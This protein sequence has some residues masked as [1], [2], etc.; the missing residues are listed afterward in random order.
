MNIQKNVTPNIYY[1]DNFLPKNFIDELRNKLLVS[2]WGIHGSDPSKASG[3]FFWAKSLTDNKH[4][5]EKE[6][7]YFEKEFNQ[8]KILRIYVNGQSFTQH[9]EFHVDDGERTYLI[10]MSEKI[11]SNSGGATEFLVDEEGQTTISI[12]PLYNRLISFPADIQ[13]RALPSFDLSIFRMT[14]AIKTVDKMSDNN[15]DDSDY[16][17]DYAIEFIS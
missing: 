4:I 7:E 2:E 9:G 12:Y 8:C 17:S 16:D 5:F 11:N 14:L 15:D 1:I 10:G 6:I 3:V 13:H